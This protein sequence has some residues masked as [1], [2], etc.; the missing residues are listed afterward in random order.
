MRADGIIA[1]LWIYSLTLF[2]ANPEA[3]PIRKLHLVK[4]ANGFG[5]DIVGPSSNSMKVSMHVSGVYVNAVTPGG[6][7]EKAGLRAG[8]RFLFID[9]V[10]CKFRPFE[11]VRDLFTS[12]EGPHTVAVQQDLVG[13]GAQTSARTRTIKRAATKAKNQASTAE[14]GTTSQSSTAAPHSAPT[15][16]IPEVGGC[17]DDCRYFFLCSEVHNFCKNVPLHFYKRTFHLS[18]ACFIPFYINLKRSH[19]MPRNSRGHVR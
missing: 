7:A 12:S 14:S 4:E 8:D 16:V 6:P 10:D 11:S 13:L 15:I 5:F 18:V 3:N 17:I 1:V 19:H 9:D 2:Q